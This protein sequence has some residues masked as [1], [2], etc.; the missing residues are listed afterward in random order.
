MQCGAGI[1]FAIFCA[2]GYDAYCMTSL[3]L[4]ASPSWIYGAIHHR[5][6]FFL[7]H[8]GEQALAQQNG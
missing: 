1:I 8:R 5:R 4:G 7:I 6:W 3:L 2:A